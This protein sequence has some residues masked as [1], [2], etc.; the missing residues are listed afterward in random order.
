MMSYQYYFGRFGSPQ[1]V[2]LA[3]YQTNAIKNGAIRAEL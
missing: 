1:T 3:R 2:Y